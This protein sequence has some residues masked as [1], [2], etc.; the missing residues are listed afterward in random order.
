[1]YFSHTVLISYILSLVYSDILESYVECDTVYYPYIVI[2]YCCKFCSLTSFLLQNH[3]TEPDIVNVVGGWQA[4]LHGDSG[5]F[6]AFLT[7]E[8]LSS[9]YNYIHLNIFYSFE[10]LHSVS[11]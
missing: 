3:V 8:A 4:P 2:L 6:L 7:C 5:C 11:Q 1:M 10:A 9:T